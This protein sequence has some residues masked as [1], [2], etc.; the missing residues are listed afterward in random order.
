MGVTVGKYHLFKRN[1]KGGSFYYYWFEQG[2]QRIIKTRGRACSEK[3]AA[4]AYYNPWL[5]IT[6]SS[7]SAMFSQLPCFGG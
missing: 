6:F 5:F 4:V 3:R 1:R 7:I 2:N